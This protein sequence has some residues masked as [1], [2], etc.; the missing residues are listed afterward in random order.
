MKKIIILLFMLF[1]LESF[2]VMNEATC[3][4]LITSAVV[5]Q[6]PGTDPAQIKPY[7]LAVCQG[8]IATVRTGTITNSGTATVAGGSS[9]GPHPV[10]STGAIQ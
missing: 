10:I 9:S 7:W 6:N 8:I 1:S 4:D 5:A 3:A 2:A